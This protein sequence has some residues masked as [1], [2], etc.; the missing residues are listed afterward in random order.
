MY[1]IAVPEPSYILSNTNEKNWN[2]KPLGLPHITKG[3]M[4]C[5]FTRKKRFVSPPIDVGEFS[6][7]L[8]KTRNF[9]LFVLI[10]Q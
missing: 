8:V 5:S 1:K 10:Y 2:N 9:F 6:T 4:I 7:K 3:Y